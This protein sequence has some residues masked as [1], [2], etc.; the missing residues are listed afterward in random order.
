M[1]GNCPLH[2]TLH[3]RRRLRG[4][5]A[6]HGDGTMPYRLSAVRIDD[7]LWSNIIHVV[8]FPNVLPLRK[9]AW[10]G[11]VALALAW[12]SSVGRNVDGVP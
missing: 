11:I 9:T 7:S 5:S 4:N 6:E 10:C 3:P 1:I 12:C 2:T 8:C